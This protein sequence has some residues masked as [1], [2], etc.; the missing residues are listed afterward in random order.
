M[1]DNE[2]KLA[3]ALMEGDEEYS[4]ASKIVSLL[5]NRGWGSKKK[6]MLD[7]G[8]KEKEFNEI[9][10]N[11]KKNKYFASRGNIN[12]DEEPN[13]VSVILMMLCAKGFIERTIGQR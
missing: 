12:L 10:N 6:I 1:N 2:R 7:S 3:D 11:I 13:D 9:W 5:L 8:V 4:D